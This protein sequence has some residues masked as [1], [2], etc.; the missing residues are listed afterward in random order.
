M[1]NQ[2]TSI[3][4]NSQ[5]VQAVLNGTKTQTRRPMLTTDNLCP[6]GKVGD[7]IWVRETY[8]INKCYDTTSPTLAY[9]AM[10]GDV[11][12]CVDYRADNNKNS[13]SGRWRPSIHMPKWA[14]RITIEIT[15]VKYEKLHNI[16]EEDAK[17]EGCSCD[18]DPNWIPSYNDP[19][20]GGNPSYKNTFEYLWDS[21]YKTWNKNPYV[22]VVEFKVV[23]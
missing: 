1:K 5:M 23:K 12:Y 2:R 6:Y 16:T 15:N 19:D 20:S 3:L 13:W 8:A 7:R 10:N 4:F 11:A 18:E 17:A 22:W 9:I 21:I 14:S